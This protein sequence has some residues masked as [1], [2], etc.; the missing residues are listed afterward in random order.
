MAVTDQKAETESQRGGAGKWVLRGLAI[1]IVVVAVVDLV[2][3]LIPVPSAPRPVSGGGQTVVYH[4]SESEDS[5]IGAKNWAE[6]NLNFVGWVARFKGVGP[7][8]LYILKRNENWKNALEIGQVLTWFFLLI[9]P[10]ALWIVS[11]RAAIRKL[12]GS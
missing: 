7:D 8:R 9:L 3:M 10:F 1:F 2:I 12:L 6:S 11:A 4:S 5:I